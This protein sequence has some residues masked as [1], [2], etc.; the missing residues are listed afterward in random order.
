MTVA[1]P[2]YKSLKE[3]KERLFDTNQVAPFQLQGYII[4]DI[5][6]NPKMF[7]TNKDVTKVFFEGY[8][9]D[10]AAIEDVFYLLQV[11]YKYTDKEKQGY[12]L[13]YPNN[14]NRLNIH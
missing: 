4:E 14:L 13:S 6:G 9:G 8:F 2:L 12:S 3:L 7:I 1:P 5:W 10:E 11:P